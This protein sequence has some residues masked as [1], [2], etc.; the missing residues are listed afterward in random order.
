MQ[1]TGPPVSKAPERL[2]TA[3]NHAVDAMDSSR[4]QIETSQ[5]SSPAVTPGG[6]HV[7]IQSVALH[8]VVAEQVRLGEPARPEKQAD[9]LTAAHR[10]GHA[11]TEPVQAEALIVDP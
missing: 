2:E 7:V 10:T 11:A 6:I 8:Q 5:P 1:A 4:P 9:V 3:L